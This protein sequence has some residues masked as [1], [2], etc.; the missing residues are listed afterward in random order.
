MKK[1][2]L[3]ILAALT[4]NVIAAQEDTTK[5]KELGELVVTGQYKP[6]SVRNSVYQ[7][8]VIDNERIRLSGATNIQQVLNTQ[9]GFR[10]SND[11]TLGTT[12]VQLMGMTGRNVKILLDGVPMIDRGD[13]RESLGQIDINSI[14]RIEI[15][16]GPMSVSYGSD[17]LAGVI[18]IITKRSTGKKLSVTAKAQEETVGDEYHPFSY[19]GVHMQNIGV[20]WQKNRWQ[21][22]AG[23]THNDFD[24][25]G[26]DQFGRAKSW[27]PKEQ[28]LGNVK[29]G[30]SKDAFNIYY[31]LDAL[32]ETITSRG[33]INMNTY[34]AIDQRYIT[35]RYT[36]QVQTGWWINNKLQLNGLAAY[37]DYQ[38]RTKTT[39]HDFE[40][41]TDELTTGVGE[42]D[43]SKFNSFI[44]R[45]TLQYNISSVI[46][47]QPGIDINHE[48]ANGERI[49]GKPSITDYALF[50]SSEIKPTSKINIR[51]GLR[52]I[53]NSV[54]D[55]P[56][57]IP[58]IN[59]KFVLN[60]ELD[61]RLAYAYGF[62]SPALRELY[63]DF[64]DASHDI[65]GNPDLKAE[66]SNSFN[67]SLSWTPANSTGVRFTSTLTGFYNQF[68]NLINYASD[69]SNPTQFTTV[70]IDKF[71]T[72]G[73]TL[74]NK[75]GWKDLN[76]T[77]GFSYIGRYNDLS[78]NKD[79]ENEN[80]PVFVWTPEIN[81]NAIYVFK[82][83]GTTFGLFYKY[84][85]KRPG[86]VTGLNTTT[87]QEEVFLTKIAS[88]HWADFT[89]TKSIFKYFSI[90]GGVKNIFDVTDLNNANVSG[91]AH[92]A[93]GPVPMSFGRSYF[94]GLNFQWDKK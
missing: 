53:K 75:I 44:F 87:G 47:L 85:G 81:T 48:V 76:V 5:P 67:G 73:G 59:T 33:A 57:V 1:N 68:R 31:R 86:Y 49:A 69:P 21:V 80:L 65:V 41:D 61:L 37:T 90:T 14:E 10:F 18:N 8:R 15:V 56:P 50:V 20:S 55:A 82:K 9:L 74:E 93:G 54:Y 13:T 62:R 38:R 79:F 19:K 70:N 60:K 24:G 92:S 91:S 34:K 84:T 72:T 27:K 4:F 3:L 88:F 6:Q 23:G 66:H 39:R 2:Y 30:Y 78:D 17:A 28:W 45:S 12:D 42:Q 7:V 46:S 83:I 43:I 94:L 36:H 52:F 16:E 22:S 58:S 29:L 71:K 89:V 26:G 64:H 35:N 40:K 51:P 32:D 25:F 77:V 11:N 63:F